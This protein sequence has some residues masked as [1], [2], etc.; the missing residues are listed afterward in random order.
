MNDQTLPHDD[1]ITAVA[2]ALDGYGITVADGG[3]SENDDL[4]DGW[5][6]FAPSSVNADAWPHGVILGWDQRNGWTL[7]EQ[8]GG[9]N[10]DPLDPTAVCTFTS[11]QQV[12]FPVANALRGRMAS[13][14]STNDGT[15]TWDPRPLEAAVAAW[16]KGES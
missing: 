12:A 7:I 1:Y 16:E 10:V 3:T 6:T 11:P 2:D 9:R 14:P 13:G 15:W 4:L 8:G 5:I